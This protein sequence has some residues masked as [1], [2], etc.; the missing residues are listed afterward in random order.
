MMIKNYHWRLEIIQAPLALRYCKKC[1][2]KTEFVSSDCFRVNANQK[3]L[4]IWLIYHCTR[5][6]T[7]WNACIHT[8][9]SPQKLSPERLATFEGNN[10]QLAASCAMD[11]VMLRSNGA[12]LGDTTYRLHT[13]EEIPS[14]PCRIHLTCA[15]DTNI[16][17]KRLIRE[18]CSLSRAAYTKLVE[19]NALHLEDGRV[20]QRARV[21]RD[22]M[23]LLG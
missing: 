15:Y 9:I 17:I 16:E 14:A 21:R 1:A 2:V 4:D 11:A 8:R 6:K 7:T 18:G 20:I 13:E 3:K 22:Q 5:C 12:E 10:P 19:Q 23:I